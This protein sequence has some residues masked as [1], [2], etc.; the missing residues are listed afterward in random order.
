MALCHFCLPIVPCYTAKVLKNESRDVRLFNFWSPVQ[1]T[2]LPKKG[3]FLE[4]LLTWLL[5]TY[6]TTNFPK[7][8]QSKPWYISLGK[9]WAKN[10]AFA[11]QEFFFE[12]STY[13]TFVYLLCPIMVQSFKKFVRVDP[14]ILIFGQNLAKIAPIPKK[15]IFLKTSLVW[16]W[17][18]YYLLKREQSLTHSF[19]YFSV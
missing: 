6:Y 7:I 8:P 2:H 13:V 3:I 14:E 11:S 10:Y 12:N 1:I 5:S 18:F 19:F 4:I 16:F 9:N 17:S 15:E